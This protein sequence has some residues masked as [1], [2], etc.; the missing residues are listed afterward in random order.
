MAKVPGQNTRVLKTHA[1]A[2]QHL[3]E[4]KRSLVTLTVAITGSMH[5]QATPAL[6]LSG[7][8]SDFFRKTEDRGREQSQ[9]KGEGRAGPG[10]TGQKRGGQGR[11]GQGKAKQGSN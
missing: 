9:G 3:K 4:T 1:T 11:A 7:R 2:G 5:C 10:R 6:L 8:K